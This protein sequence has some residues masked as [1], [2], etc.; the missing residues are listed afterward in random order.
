M[1]IIVFTTINIVFLLCTYYMNFASTHL[2][3]L[4]LSNR[5]TEKKNSKRAT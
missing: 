1:P 2:M 4:A 3:H 5:N